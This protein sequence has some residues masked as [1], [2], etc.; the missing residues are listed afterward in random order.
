MNDKKPGGSDFGAFDQRADVFNVH[1]QVADD[2]PDLGICGQH[3][4][5]TQVALVCLGK[6][7]PILKRALRGIGIGELYGTSEIYAGA[8]HR[9]AS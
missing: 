3:L 5:S 1:T 8:D 2:V 9:E 6:T 4:H 7:G